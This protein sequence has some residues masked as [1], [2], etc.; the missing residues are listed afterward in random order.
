MGARV[1]VIDD[2]A[3]IR[4]LVSAILA[5]HGYVPVVANDGR[6]GLDKLRSADIE[7]V[8]LD[9]AL[10]KMSARQF[11]K[12]VREDARLQSIPIV[13]MS[14]KPELG[15]EFLQ[16][17]DVVGAIGKPF[18]P[19]DLIDAVETA[20]AEEIVAELEED[21]V[22][23]IS[24]SRRRPSL[25]TSEQ[26]TKELARLL[27]PIVAGPVAE[28]P[29]DQRRDVHAIEAVLGRV[30]PARLDELAAAFG[31]SSEPEAAAL[32]GDIS[33]IA[34]GEILQVLHFQR[35][36]GQL[37]VRSGDV[38]VA[39]YLREGLVDLVQ[40]HGMSEKLRLGRYLVEEGLVTRD[41]LEALLRD[42]SEKKLLGEML[43]ELGVIGDDELKQA[44]TRQSSEL[45]YEL[46]RWSSGR[47]DFTHRV[48]PYE[49]RAARLSMSV[50]SV[51]ME[52]FRR[53]DEWQ[54]IEESLDFDEV[55]FCDDGALEA[56]DSAK[57]S[58]RERLVLKAI[59]G[60]SSAR[61]IVAKLEVSP[62][63]AYKTLYELL[64]SRLVR[65]R[66]A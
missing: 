43:V 18:R 42:R 22:V 10:S 32:S 14:A 54:L 35:Q 6:A 34:L 45:I 63:D 4:K 62:F 29:D 23:E 41:E 59:D 31:H 58:H 16:R 40:G 36:T 5:R 17:G 1:L 13:L 64:R 39:V 57:L 15:D 2:S 9:A 7:L 60:R 51:V 48:F 25:V 66:A 24:E 44:L 19:Q 26:T 61:E 56:A 3:T 37:R 55:L 20:L 38:E 47:F 52:G 33:T 8:I 65:R 21:D 49:A 50:A 53:I 28:L 30:L 11:C 12:T 27:A 46:L